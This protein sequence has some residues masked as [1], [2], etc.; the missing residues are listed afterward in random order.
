MKTKPLALLAILTLAVTTG[1]FMSTLLH[2]S[3]SGADLKL[4][5]A[6]SLLS[7]GSDR[8]HVE[9]FLLI[10]S[11]SLVVFFLIGKSGGAF[12]TSIA[13]ITPQI[14]TPVAH[15]QF[16]HGS[17]RWLHDKEKDGLFANYRIER[18]FTTMVDRMR[19]G[20]AS[21]TEKAKWEQEHK[22]GLVLGMN[23]VGRTMYYVG[24]D[25][26]TLIV[27]A[28][29]SGKT[30]CLV[31]PTICSL[32]LAGESLVI[33]DPKAELYQTTS[34]L[35][36][37]LGYEVLTIDFRNPEKSQRYNLLQPIIDALQAGRRDEAEM[38]TW[39][40]TNILVGKNSHNEK[41]WHDGEMSVIAATILCVVYDNMDQ[42]QYQNL[43]NV[44]WFL[45]EMCKYVGETMPILHYMDN[46]SEDHPARPLLSIS[47]IAPEKTK[48]SFYTSAL[49]TLRLFTSRSISAM[50]SVSDFSLS[51]AG[52]KKQALFLIVPDENTT[53]YPLVSLLV[54]Q[55][56]ALLTR[57]ADRRGGRLS[58]RVN[59][60]LDEFGNFA[61]ILD[62]TNK[63]TVSAGRGMRFNLFLQ[64]FE[65]LKEKY[66]NEV[67][68]TIKSNC[69]TWVYLQADDP[70]TLEEISR[71]LGTYTTS[72]YQRSAS[73]GRYTQSS[74][75]ES[76]SLVERRLLTPDEVRRLNRP[77]QIVTTRSFPALM[78][79]PDLSA[80]V[81]ND[82][83]GLGSAEQNRIL[84][85][86]KEAERPRR[87]EDGS[88]PLW[89]IWREYKELSEIN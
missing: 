66:G 51:E 12:K 48:G 60:V 50:T 37:S 53:F 29:R 76:Y 30:R 1:F 14:E 47:D 54:S 80:W 23:K 8:R 5:P 59:Y 20:L 79:A 43:T 89:G 87:S 35:L 46:M 33:S 49:T 15:G 85:E 9:L 73:A 24:D 2:L 16:Q 3:L 69:Q 4:S 38:L 39:D 82:L 84:R 61:P 6:E 64:N 88:L 63:L 68:T 21:E 10:T 62:F 44:Y 65:Q 72:S 58:R 56:Y 13:Q 41:I 74:S 34:E 42:P 78:Y 57:E 71:K 81:F 22:G 77:Y 27:G 75:S 83:L 25:S 19:H 31:I 17:A 40:M 11:L 28:T 70:E 7:L 18:R 32:G 55:Q 67:A 52:E 86:R 45:A 26:H 36:V